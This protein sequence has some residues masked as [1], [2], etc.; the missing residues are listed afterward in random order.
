MIDSDF[1]GATGLAGVVWYPSD[2]SRGQIIAELPDDLEPRLLPPGGSPHFGGSD[3]ASVLLVDDP[4]AGLIEAARRAMIPVVVI[5]DTAH[6]APVARGYVSLTLPVSPATL[7][8]VL[9]AACEQARVTRE[10]RETTRQL[11]ELNAIG[12]RL[13]GERDTKLLLDL[14]LT[15]ART[16]TRSDAGSIYL[17]ESSTDGARQLRFELAQNESVPVEFNSVALPL[18]PKS[19]AGHV[20]LTGEILHVDDAYALPGQCAYRFNPEVDALAGYR[21]KSMLVLPMKTPGDEIIGVLELINCK[22]ES[23]RPFP[24]SEAIERE[25]LSYSPAFRNLAASLASQAAVALSNSNL[26][27]ELTRRQ[28]RL[29]ALVDVSQRVTRLWPPATVQRRIADLYCNLLQAEVV[30]FHLIED[31][32]LVRAE[33]RGEGVDVLLPAEIAVGEGPLGQVAASGEP[34]AIPEVVGSAGLTPPQV[35]IVARLGLRAWLSVP[36][37]AGDRL[38]GVLSAVTSQ[39]STCSEDD[40]A[41]ATTF[42]AQAGIAVENSRLYAELERALEGVQKSQDQL[43]QVERLRA[44]GEMAAGVAHDF[45]NLLAIVMLRTELLLARNQPQEVAE[46][47]GFIRQAAQDGAQTVRRIQEFTRTRSIRPFSPVDMNKVIREVVDLARP[48][49]KDQAQSCGVT[50]DVQ[51]DEG[52]IPKVAGTAEELREAFLN[53]LNN[54]LDAMPAG[55][56][57]TFR[58]AT[59]GD[60]V[61]VRAEDRGCGMSEETRRRVFEPFFSTKGAQGNGLGLA[62]VWGIVT[63]HSGEIQVEST[64]GRGTTFVVS[65]PVPAELPVDAGAQGPATIPVGKRVLVVEDNPEILHSLGDLLRESGCQ[66]VEAPDGLAGIGRL[67]AER[68]DLVLTDL[69][70]PGASGWEVATACREKFPSTPIGLI[71]GFGDRLEPDKIERHGV[72]FVVAKPFTS[73]ELLRE[74][75]AA[76]KAD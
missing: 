72:R 2:F 30:A 70:M 42:A 63:R 50:Y 54:A 12:V 11:E 20:A 74:V 37:R 27:R 39:P 22:R 23:G 34:L 36:V 26:F 57:F 16:I 18:N 68:V 60:R 45:N 56:R 75:A 41:V 35:E 32:R 25:A 40:V 29:E 55:G 15:K 8:S 51:V 44:L 61:V 47:L 19:L 6:S 33:A 62:V 7:A 38:V 13:S 73:T 17:V 64:L 24:S 48:R 28:G 67:E 46:S 4:D 53:L 66:V 49:W 59:E 69:A 58:T 76:L 1:S 21:T 31:R 5:S 9:R 14:I 52:R 43:V 65:L 10:A 71:T 3:A